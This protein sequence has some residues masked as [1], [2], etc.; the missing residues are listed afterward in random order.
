M[1]DNGIPV[2]INYIPA[3]GLFMVN[4]LKKVVYL[5]ENGD[6]KPKSIE[7]LDEVVV[8]KEPNDDDKNV[9]LDIE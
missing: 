5:D 2:T 3:K 8:W 9:T 1:E 4:R 6:Y 7:Q